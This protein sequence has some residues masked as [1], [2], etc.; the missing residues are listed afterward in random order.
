MRTCNFG[1]SESSPTKLSHD[2]PLGGGDNPGTTFEGESTT[3][4][5]FG[6]AN[7]QN[8]VQF[9]TTFNFD[10]EYLRNP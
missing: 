5:K 6:R 7:V 3:P 8:L 1:D 2:V 9:R 4:L 10:R